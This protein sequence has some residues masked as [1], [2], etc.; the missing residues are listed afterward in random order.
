MAGL[1]KEVEAVYLHLDLDFL[2][3]EELR[4][5][6]F[7]APGGLSLEQALE[8]VRLVRERLPLAAAALTA[9]DPDYDPEGRTAGAAIRLMEELAGG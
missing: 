9:F 4:A 5:N 1:E 6:H 2:S 8:G 7:D 3:Q